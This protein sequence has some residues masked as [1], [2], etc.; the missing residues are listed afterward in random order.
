MAI[1]QRVNNLILDY[2]LPLNAVLHCGKDKPVIKKLPS[3][4]VNL[5]RETIAWWSCQLC[6]FY[7][8]GNK[9]TQENLNGIF[10]QVKA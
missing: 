10:N 7:N 2:M 6:K 4:G 1:Q 9:L 3:T 5:K 8:A